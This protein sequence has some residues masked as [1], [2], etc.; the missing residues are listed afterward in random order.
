MVLS[1]M[2]QGRRSN[3]SANLKFLSESFAKV[4]DE[5]SRNTGLKLKFTSRDLDALM[6]SSVF[7]AVLKFVAGNFQFV[8]SPFLQTRIYN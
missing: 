5:L 2:I 8:F 1:G 6:L 4:N 3:F 7:A